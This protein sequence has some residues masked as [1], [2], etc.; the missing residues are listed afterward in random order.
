MPGPEVVARTIVGL[1]GRPR[2]EVIVPGYYSLAVLV[3]GVA[4]WLVDLVTR[5]DRSQH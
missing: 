4:P 1:I 3:E 2:R 5:G